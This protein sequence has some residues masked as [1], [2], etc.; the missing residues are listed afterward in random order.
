M[1]ICTT[2]DPLAFGLAIHGD[3]E[4]LHPDFPQGCLCAD[5]S[6]QRKFRDI[7][8]VCIVR[9]SVMKPYVVLPGDRSLVDVSG[10]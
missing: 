10:L 5:G 6:A 7:H 9:P 8:V 1:R 4:G 2:L 3:L